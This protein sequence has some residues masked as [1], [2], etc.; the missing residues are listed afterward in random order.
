MPEAQEVDLDDAEVGAVVLVPLDDHAAGHRGGLQ[1]HHV[2]E[3]ALG[4]D[5]AARV[6]AEVARQVLDLAE[7][8]R[9]ELHA[10]VVP[11]EARLGERR[12]H[13]CRRGRRT[14]SGA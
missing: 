12:S 9:E 4:D 13:A 1:G 3:G 11:V 5:H 8:A 2:V 6:L 7:E 10:A 14:R